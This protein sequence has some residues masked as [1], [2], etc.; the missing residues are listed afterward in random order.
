MGI[1]YRVDRLGRDPAKRDVPTYGLGCIH[2]LFL[3]NADARDACG[4]AESGR[5]VRA[6]GMY[7]VS[8][9][10]TDEAR[11][12]I[13]GGWRVA[14]RRLIGRSDGTTLCDL[15]VV[16]DDWDKGRRVVS[17]HRPG[18]AV[19]CGNVKSRESGD[20][21][22]MGYDLEMIFRQ[23][24]ANDR[25]RLADA[26]AEMV[27]G[28]NLERH[29][30]LVAQCGGDEPAADIRRL[31]ACS[32]DYAHPKH[33]VAAVKYAMDRLDTLESESD[34]RRVVD[35]TAID[36]CHTEELDA[37]MRQ[38][39]KENAS[40]VVADVIEAGRQMSIPKDALVL[41]SSHEDIDVNQPSIGQDIICDEGQYAARLFGVPV[42]MLACDVQE[43]T[44]IVGFVC[45]GVNEPRRI[46]PPL[47]ARSADGV[48]LV[49]G[50]LDG[51]MDGA[52]HEVAKEII[53]EKL[54]PEYL[55][56]IERGDAG[57]IRKFMNDKSLSWARTEVPTA[58]AD[59]QRNALRERISKVQD[60]P[61]TTAMRSRLELRLREMEAIQRHVELNRHVPRNPA[62]LER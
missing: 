57:F 28:D 30:A 42:V 38:A 13:E 43:R 3:S 25:E 19:V 37:A 22:W 36:T 48:T 39:T 26:I 6:E 29:R 12:L 45:D 34:Y 15:A 52:S 47:G 53:G 35:M 9:I 54:L 44:N 4:L 61:Y 32:A 51:T 23:S 1:V 50:A 8:R 59:Q 7:K 18:K 62:E 41:N 17:V 58:L 55:S 56:A 33:V 21:S 46:N 11:K 16:G 10:E 14:G 27:V 20:P 60:I 40:K 5:G 2:S 49:P 24:T 31:A